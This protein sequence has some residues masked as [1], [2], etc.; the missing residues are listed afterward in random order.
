MRFFLYPGVP[1]N[2]W[3]PIIASQARVKRKKGRKKS[4][5]SI[6]LKG[7]KNCHHCL[8][9]CMLLWLFSLAW[10]HFP[11]LSLWRNLLFRLKRIYAKKWLLAWSPMHTIAALH[12]GKFFQVGFVE[13]LK[14][15]NCFCTVHCFSG[16]K[17]G[18][19][20]DMFLSK[21]FFSLLSQATT[22]R[23]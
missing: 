10:H 8:F 15:K 9:Y 7:H 12:Y 21:L 4:S 1:C 18:L 16:A 22:R 17:K 2:Y 14:E 19:L 13:K 11:R 23:T 20:H 6:K 5:R 3:Q